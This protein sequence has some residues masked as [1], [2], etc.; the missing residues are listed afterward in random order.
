[1]LRPGERVKGVDAAVRLLP[2]PLPDFSRNRRRDRP[3]GV[4]ERRKDP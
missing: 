4:Q 3:M 1:M 2:R